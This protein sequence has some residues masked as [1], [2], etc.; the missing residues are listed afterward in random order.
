MGRSRSFGLRTGA[1]G[2]GGVAPAV[3]EPV[4]VLALAVSPNVEEDVRSL[5]QHRLGGG[6]SDV[7]VIE[8][9]PGACRKNDNKQTKE[10]EQRAERAL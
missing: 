5:L 4:A 9:I 2:G 8:V 1:T 3:G 7:A 6:L 10:R